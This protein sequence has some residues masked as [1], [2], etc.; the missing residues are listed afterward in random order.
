[1]INVREMAE[2]VWNLATRALAE[3]MNLTSATATYGTSE[4]SLTGLMARASRLAAAPCVAE[5]PVNFECKTT[6]VIQLKDVV[7]RPLSTWLV[8][9]EVLG[10]LCTGV[11]E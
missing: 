1:M 8:L 10:K 9:G 6:D 2:F 11:K 5:S 4:F 3:P 7:G